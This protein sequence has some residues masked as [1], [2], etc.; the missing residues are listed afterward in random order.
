MSKTFLISTTG[1]VSPVVI[2]DLGA[3]S[4]PHPATVN[5]DLTEDYSLEQI[6][7]SE[8]LRSAIDAGDLTA[9]FD[10]ESITTGALFDQYMVDFDHVQVEQNTTNIATNTSDIS[11]LKNGGGRLHQ[12]LDYVDNTAVPPTEVDGNRYILDN[13]GSSNAAWDGAAG[14][15]LVQFSSTSGLWEVKPLSSGN[16]SY[17]LAEGFDR[18]YVDDGTPDWEARPGS[19][20]QNATQVP[21]TPTTPSDWDAV[22]TEVGG[23]ADELASRVEVLENTP[24]SVKKSWTYSAGDN[25]NVGSSKDLQRTGNSRTN[26]TPFIAPVTGTIWAITVATQQG[27]NETYDIQII[28]NG[29]VQHTESVSATDSAFN[30]A[31]AVSVSAGDAIRIRFIRTSGAVRDIGVELYGIES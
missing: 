5:F 24:P 16:V 23:A 4:F 3:I 27:T 17:V 19:K 30:N 12:V 15:S 8:D 2:S 31:L 13:T 22:P 21:Y 20:I 9:V 6:R 25:A 1:T 10:T 18:V 29:A 26:L 14:L 11:L 7:E 28:V